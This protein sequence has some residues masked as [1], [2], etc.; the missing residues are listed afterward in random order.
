VA[1]ELA[2]RRR[3]WSANH[4]RPE[5][6]ELRAGRVLPTRGLVAKHVDAGCASVSLKC[7]PSPPMTYL[8]DTISQNF[9]PIW[10]PHWPTCMC[11]IS[12]EK[13]S[14]EE[15]STREIKGGEEREN[16]RNS[17]R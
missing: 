13:S 9:V 16:V 14:L 10:L 5:F 11:K 4:A 12:R 7:S 17:V 3:A 2:E 6:E 1:E 8:S 15:G